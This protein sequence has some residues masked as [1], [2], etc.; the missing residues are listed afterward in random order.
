MINA[1]LT[2]GNLA[3]GSKIS[4]K[5]RLLEPLGNGN[6]LYT[7]FV[8]QY[9]K[10][11]LLETREAFNTRG[12]VKLHHGVKENRLFCKK[13]FDR[14]DQLESIILKKSITTTESDDE[15]DDN[16]PIARMKNFDSIN[17]KLK[18]KSTR[19]QLVCKIIFFC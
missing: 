2:H 13:M 4:T 6:I 10:H 17:L 3:S 18:N 8:H 16:F 5:S 1:L 15:E 12:I 19:T 7:L 11:L 9:L 14:M